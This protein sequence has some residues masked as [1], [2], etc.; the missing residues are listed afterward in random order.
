MLDKA[1]PLTLP[2]KLQELYTKVENNFYIN[3][4]QGEFKKA[5]IPNVQMSEM[6]KSMQLKMSKFSTKESLRDIVSNFLS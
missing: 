5:I 1:N 4:K 6:I 3:L 2:P